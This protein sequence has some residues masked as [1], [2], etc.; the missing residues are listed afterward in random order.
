MFQQF[1]ERFTK[2]LYESFYQTP[3]GSDTVSSE[4]KKMWQI[5]LKLFN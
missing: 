3:N 4:L 5:S 2:V 1:R